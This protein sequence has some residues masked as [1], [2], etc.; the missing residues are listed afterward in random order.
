VLFDTT[1]DQHRLARIAA[2]TAQLQNNQCSMIRSAITAVLPPLE[3]V[4]VTGMTDVGELPF[5]KQAAIS[6]SEP[7][8]E[9][10]QHNPVAQLS[11]KV[12]SRQE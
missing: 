9:S 8:K 5:S 10:L 7:R 2:D 4:V 1:R 3:G 12:E 11:G 6:R